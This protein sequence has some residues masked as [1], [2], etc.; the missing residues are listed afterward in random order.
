[1]NK[2]KKELTKTFVSNIRPR[3]DS[4]VTPVKVTGEAGTQAQEN[5]KRKGETT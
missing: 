4:K 2:E 5:K 1:M 3:V